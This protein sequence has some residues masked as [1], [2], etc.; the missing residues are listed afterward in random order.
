MSD[1]KRAGVYFALL[2]A[3]VV[4]VNAWAGTA[5]PSPSTAGNVN[6]VIV[7]AQDGAGYTYGYT[8]SFASTA[9]A[10]DVMNDSAND[11]RAADATFTSTMREV[12]ITLLNQPD[13]DDAVCVEL[14]DAY[15]LSKGSGSTGV[16]ISPAA[17]MQCENPTETNSLGHVG[18][19]LADR[20]ATWTATIR[21]KTSGCT[22]WATCHQ[23][24]YVMTDKAGP[25]TH[26]L[27]NVQVTLK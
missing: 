20:G 25:T 13:S 22:S 12:I 18:S 16:T 10:V 17:N 1:T 26:P 7:N 27:I 24:I 5:P 9:T 2:V 11:L 21:P 23:P 4:G 8:V 14:G 19:I 15:G 3:L 6:S